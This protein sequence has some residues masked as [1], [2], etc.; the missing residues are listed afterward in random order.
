MLH[1]LSHTIASYFVAKRWL[2]TSEYDWCVY[3]VERRL[4]TCISFSALLLL[5]FL[6]GFLTQASLFLFCFMLLRRRAGGYHAKTPLRCFLTS[7][8][9]LLVALCAAYP[10]LLIVAGLSSILLCVA[11]AALVLALGAIN[12]PAM[13]QT[14]AELDANRVLARRIALA[15]ACALSALALW[16]AA[17]QYALAG[18]LGLFAAAASMAVAKMIHQEVKTA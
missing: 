18:A 8:G 5:S 13:A 6:L 14:K 2:S 3:A 12:H 16:P 11:A 7:A 17:A 4:S 15:L 10:A 1:G 9:I